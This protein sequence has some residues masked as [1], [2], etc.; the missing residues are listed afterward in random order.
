MISFDPVISTGDVLTIVGFVFA[1]AAARS[2][3]NQWRADLTVKLIDEYSSSEVRHARSQLR[4]W[5]REVGVEGNWS[6][7][8]AARF[9]EDE[10]FVSRTLATVNRYYNRVGTLIRQGVLIER[11]M[12]GEIRADVVI[13]EPVLRAW[14][15]FT[16][17]RR[18]A[19]LGLVG[20]PAQLLDGYWGGTRFLMK[21]C[22]RS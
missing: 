15:E 14:T 1:I 16:T 8:I 13:F 5:A 17:E 2:G 4:R 20:A 6:E 3:L 11:L 22:G 21:K 18:R 7:A 12:L 19:D 9:V 10:E